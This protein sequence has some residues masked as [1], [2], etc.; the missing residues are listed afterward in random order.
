ME[1]KN[2]VI[3]I[4]GASSGIGEATARLLTQKGAKVVLVARS[5]TKLQKLSKILPG[6]LV[7]STDMTDV[8]QIQSLVVKVRKHFGRID[9]LINN[10]GIGYDASVEKT[11]LAKLQRVYDLDLKGPILAMQAVIPL[12]RSQGGGMIVNVSSATTLMYLPFMGGYSGIKRALNAVTLTAR[13]ELSK[14]KII[15]SVVYPYMTK[16]DFEKNTLSEHERVWDPENSGLD[17]PLPDPPELVA[18]KIAGLIT[19][20]V[21]EMMVHDWT[22]KMSAGI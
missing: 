17:I 5:E 4:T 9:I 21:P 3:I 19:S 14:D 16:T 10:A 1:I 12:M 7:I 22:P 6:S 2:K 20:E 8:K 11:D 15:V 13:Q 18:E